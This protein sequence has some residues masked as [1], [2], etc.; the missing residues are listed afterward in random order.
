MLSPNLKGRMQFAP[1]A[2][3]GENETT[4]EKHINN[5][6]NDIQSNNPPPQINPIKRIRLFAG[7]G[8]W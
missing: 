7:M 2:S 4:D 1:T 3:T 8:K 5:K 6:I